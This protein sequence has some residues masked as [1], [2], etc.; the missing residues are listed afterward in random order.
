MTRVLFISA[1]P[2][3]RSMSGL[4]IRYAELARVLAPYAEVTIAHGGTGEDPLDDV[5]TTPYAPHAPAALKPLIDAADVV[6]THPQW[7][8]LS[9]W[10]R[11]SG[12]RVVYDLY[13][14]ETLETLELFSGR[15]LPF[16]RLMHHTS[17]DRLHDALATGRHFMCASETQRDLYLGALLAQR[18]IDPATYDRDASLR[19]TIDTVP[20]GV[21]AEPPAVAPGTRGPRERF[22]V[23]GADAEIVLWNGGIWNWLDPETAIRAVAK[24]SERRPSVRL[25]FMGA[26]DRAAGA[27]AA[28]RAR[29]L[30][31]AL[32]LTDRL[33]LFNEDWVPY[34]ERGA[35]LTQADCALSTH[36]EHLETRFAFR[37]RLLDCFWAGLPVV[38][39]AGDDLA[40][41]IERDGLGGVAAPGDVPGTAAAIERVLDAGR[42]A[43]A[44]PLARAAAEHAWPRV[45]AP[46]V[47]WVTAPGD[48]RPAVP[49]T[50][51]RTLGHRARA[52][53]Y[54]AGGRHVL[55]RRGLG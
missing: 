22:T 45:A 3:G 42:A 53:V 18:R 47:R 30:A 20:F 38:C 5:R 33:V 2:V 15:K 10:L 51:S 29:A 11:R 26:S 13:A 12:A 24:L 28:T 54:S 21:P 55:R 4:G 8:V 9:G 36:P 14:P 40:E 35:W 7:P 1:D 44:E 39:S 27:Q 17:L 52:A 16:R 37:T 19:D 50:A 41:R 32:G 49:G 48:S 34:E 6:V 46:L 25:L 23:V 43:F 31:G